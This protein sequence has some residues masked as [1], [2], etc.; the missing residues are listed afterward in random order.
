MQPTNIHIS[1][2]KR[3]PRFVLVLQ[4]PGRVHHVTL[5]REHDLITIDAAIQAAADLGYD[6]DGWVAVEP[7]S[8][9][10]RCYATPAVAA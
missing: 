3:H 2:T 10:A 6:M 8:P 7:A 9:F 5:G 4:A 1:T